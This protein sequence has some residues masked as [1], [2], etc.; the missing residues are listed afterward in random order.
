MDAH[1]Y[2]K[3]GYWKEG[4]Y[5][6]DDETLLALSGNWSPPAELEGGETD[7]EANESPLKDGD[8]ILA[9]HRQTT[10]SG[11]VTVEIQYFLQACMD[12]QYNPGTPEDADWILLVDTHWEEGDPHGNIRLFKA[13]SVVTLNDAKTG[14]AVMNVC[15]RKDGAYGM[16][17]VYGNSYY[18]KP[19]LEGLWKEIAPV[20]FPGT[21]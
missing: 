7:A 2:G 5:L 4:V 16:I 20:L 14:K 6:T 9:V 3:P 21:K 12:E 8:K 15:T 1:G 17:T 19:R 13:M 11:S 18:Q 10:V